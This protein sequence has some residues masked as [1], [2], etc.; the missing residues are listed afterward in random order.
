MPTAQ[1]GNNGLGGIGLTAGGDH[2]GLGGLKLNGEYKSN[3]A[4]GRLQN[5]GGFGQQNQNNN[6]SDAMPELGGMGGGS[7]SNES[8][9]LYA[10]DGNNNGGESHE[11]DGLLGFNGTGEDK[12]ALQDSERMKKMLKSSGKVDKVMNK[13][14]D[15]CV[16]VCPKKCCCTMKYMWKYEGQPLKL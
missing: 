5:K 7:N 3:S 4:A 10:V 11:T 12:A 14:L 6:G 1:G 9:S 16:T 8:N 15:K 13:C 2:G